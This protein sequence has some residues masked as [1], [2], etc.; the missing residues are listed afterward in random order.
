MK[1][2][3]PPPL[4]SSNARETAKIAGW[5]GVALNLATFGTDCLLLLPIRSGAQIRPMLNPMIWLFWEFIGLCFAISV[6]L[7]PRR[8]HAWWLAALNLCP[9]ITG[10]VTLS[11]IIRVKHFILEP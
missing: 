7:P 9:I 10:L 3:L 11:V 4:P 2:L 6:L 8:R 1:P 5:A